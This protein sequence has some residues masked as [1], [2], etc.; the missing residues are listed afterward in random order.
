MD[1]PNEGQTDIDTDPRKQF[2]NHL[3][4][5]VMGM[6]EREGFH[7]IAQLSPAS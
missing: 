3:K 7:Q 2:L 5:E 1:K 4:K 6:C